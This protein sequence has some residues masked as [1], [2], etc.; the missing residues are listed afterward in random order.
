[1]VFRFSKSRRRDILGPA[2]L[3]MIFVVRRIIKARGRTLRKM[4]QTVLA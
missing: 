4:K 1:M 3:Y 2:L